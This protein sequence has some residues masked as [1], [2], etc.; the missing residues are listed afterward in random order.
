MVAAMPKR[1]HTCAWISV[2]Q[3][4]EVQPVATAGVGQDQESGRTTVTTGSFAF[5]PGG[6]GMGGEGRSV[7]RDADTDRAA[8]VGWVINAVGDAHSAGIGAEIVI[9]HQN[10]RAIPFGTG[11]FEVADQFAFLAV[12]ANDGKALSL[13]ASPERADMLELLIAVGAGVGGDLLTVDAQR[14]IHL[15]EKTSDGIGRD[16]DIDLSENL[17]DLLGR[18]AG[19]LQTGDGISGGVVLQKNLDGI[20]YFGRFFSTRLRPAPALRARSTSTS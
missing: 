11:V 18:L 2:F 7:M 6:D 12:D 17:R 19:P 1:L 20:D 13:E 5:P 4:Q 15:V 14:E 9:V 10:G 3:A 16:R 8:I